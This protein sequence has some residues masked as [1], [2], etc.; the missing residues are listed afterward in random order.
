MIKQK[1]SKNFISNKD[2]LE[3]LYN[4]GKNNINKIE[5]ILSFKKPKELILNPRLNRNKNHNDYERQTYN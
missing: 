4:D 2:L 5:R 3:K 1:N